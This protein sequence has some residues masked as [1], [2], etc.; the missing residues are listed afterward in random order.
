MVLWI[1]AAGF[2]IVPRRH[3]D[4]EDWIAVWTPCLLIRRY[5]MTSRLRDVKT[6][7]RG[8]RL[9]GSGVWDL[10]FGIF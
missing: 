4:T 9:L 2:T 7:R 6:P 3:G 5:P 1:S 10:G 8:I